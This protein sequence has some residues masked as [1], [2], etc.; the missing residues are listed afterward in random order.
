MKKEIIEK[1]LQEESN[2]N[3]VARAE[4][5]RFLVKT[6][7]N[8]VKFDRPEGGGFDGRDGIERQSLAKIVDAA[9][10]HYSAMIKEKHKDK[11]TNK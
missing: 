2:D 3:P 8:F 11:L 6:V 9:E 4:I 1:W 5:A 7:Y 10:Y